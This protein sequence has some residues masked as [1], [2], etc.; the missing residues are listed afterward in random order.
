MPADFA[1]LLQSS[2]AAASVGSMRDRLESTEQ[3]AVEEA[4]AAEG[5]N[6]TRAAR[7]LG[8]SRRTLVYKLQK[9]QLRDRGPKDG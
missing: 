5:G 2:A 8:V 7:R 9:Y 1:E 6:Q 3:R 4:L